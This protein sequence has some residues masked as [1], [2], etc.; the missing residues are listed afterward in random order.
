MP[1]KFPLNA[2]F[3]NGLK[4]PNRFE[5]DHYSYDFH[6]YILTLLSLQDLLK[7]SVRNIDETGN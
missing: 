4:F 2:S 7:I 5:R 3:F 1:K 6:T